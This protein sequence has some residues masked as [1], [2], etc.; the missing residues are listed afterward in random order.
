V[1]I[2]V[3]L[4]LLYPIPIFPVVIM[5]VGWV[6]DRQGTLVVPVEVGLPIFE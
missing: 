3:R 4:L 2:I 5:E 6:M 1:G